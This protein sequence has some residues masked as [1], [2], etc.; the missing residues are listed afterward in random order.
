MRLWGKSWGEGGADCRKAGRGEEDVIC[1]MKI[2]VQ[3]P[4]L[5]PQLQPISNWLFYYLLRPPPTNTTTKVQELLNVGAY[6]LHES[7]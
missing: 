2:S 1:L 6:D 4:L 7:E 5:H 3:E